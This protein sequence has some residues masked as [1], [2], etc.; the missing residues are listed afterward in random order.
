[1]KKAAEK[2]GYNVSTMQVFGDIKNAVTEILENIPTKQKQCLIFGGEP[3]VKVLGKGTGGRN[4]ELVL[5][6]AKKY[7]KRK[8]TSNCI[9][10]NRWN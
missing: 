1:M 9:Y 6:I 5:T 2:K 7:S 10:G 3:T 4:Q 8:E